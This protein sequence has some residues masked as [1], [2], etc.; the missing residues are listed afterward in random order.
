MTKDEYLDAL[1]IAA[2]KAMGWRLLKEF[3]WWDEANHDSTPYVSHP[4]RLVTPQRVWDPTHND[5]QIGMLLGKVLGNETRA[6]RLVLDRWQSY[7]EMA[8]DASCA[9]GSGSAQLVGVMRDE[10]SWRVA[11][12]KA[13]IVACGGELPEEPA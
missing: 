6:L 9:I 8:V 5:A 10:T 1:N 13:L 7:E 12:V 11:L 4:H 3:V 2:G